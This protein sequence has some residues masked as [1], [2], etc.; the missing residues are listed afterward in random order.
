M[1]AAG[2]TN[3]VHHL[4]CPRTARLGSGP[5]GEDR[6]GGGGTAGQFVRYGAP[7]PPDA[8]RRRRAALA[9]PPAL[10]TS[11]RTHRQRRNTYTA[12]RARPSPTWSRTECRRQ[13]ITGNERPAPV[14]RAPPL[15]SRQSAPLRPPQVG[16]A[17]LGLAPCAPRRAGRA[18][19]ARR[20]G[21]RAAR[22]RGA[23]VVG[24]RAGELA[25]GG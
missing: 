9:T 23:R 19:S 24:A 5:P 16:P 6:R 17:P 10:D 3:Y 8:R 4:E 22:V 2:A 7:G 1:P 13:Q 14:G 11:T 12:R 18:Q 20:A 21:S 25:A 15:R